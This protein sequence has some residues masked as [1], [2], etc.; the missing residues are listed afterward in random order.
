MKQIGYAQVRAV[1]TSLFFSA[2]V[3][4][5]VLWF[6][7]PRVTTST[8]AAM[9]KM[10]PLLLEQLSPRREHGRFLIE[11]H[12]HPITAMPNTAV[13]P[14]AR[15]ALLQAYQQA[16]AAAQASVLDTLQVLEAT[17]AVSE[18]R[19]LWIINAIAV[20]GSYTA[21]QQIAADPAVQLIRP[22]PIVHTLNP[23]RED[24]TISQF[25]APSSTA[26]SGDNW[27]PPR[28][29]APY[30]WHGLGI[31]GD[32]V[33]IAIMDS[34]VDWQHPVLL[35]N[36]RGNL[37]GG[38]YLH[39]G[40]WFDTDDP[41]QT[42]P[43]DLIGHGTHV[44]GIAVGQR[45]I[46]VAPGAQWI[47]VKIA[48]AQGNIYESDAHAGFQWLLAPDG[49]PNLAPDI[50]NGS[51]GSTQAN[52]TFAPDLALLRQAGIIPVFSTGNTG[53]GANTVG[54]PAGLEGVIAVGASAVDDTVASFSSRG[55]SPLTAEQKPW[56]VA[57]G[58]GIY[59]AL[60]GGEFGLKSGTSMAAP[61]VSGAVALLLSAQPDLSD[62]EVRQ[63]LADTVVPIQPPHPNNDAGYGRLDIY[64]SV[65]PYVSTGTFT[66]IVSEA[67]TPLADVQVMIVNS[68]GVTLTYRTGADG[69]FTAVLQPG[70]Y[71][72]QV[73]EFL[74][75]PVLYKDL[76]LPA[77][78]IYI[79]NIP[80]TRKPTGQ[81]SGKITNAQ[82][83]PLA[84][85]TVQVQQTGV[86]AVS[87]A[88]GSYEIHLPAGEYIL[89]TEKNGFRTALQ[90][91][92]VAAGAELT[93]NF[94]LVDAPTI[95]LVDSGAWYYGS[96][97]DYY[98]ATLQNGGYSYDLWT[99]HSIINDVP[100]EA[101]LAA[102][103]TVIWSAPLDSPGLI[104]ADAALTAYL[105]TGGNLFIAG[106]DVGFYDGDQFSNVRWWTEKLAAQFVGER[107]NV[108]SLAGIEETPFTGLTLPIN[109]PDSAGNQFLP[110]VSAPRTLS[111]T[112]S[113]FQYETGETGGLAAGRC[114]PYNILYLGAGL[115]GIG[116]A[117][118]RTQLLE[119]AITTLNAPPVQAGLIISPRETNEFALPG[120]QQVYTLTVQN[121]SETV[122]DTF[123]FSYD[124]T[125]FG[126]ELI[127]KTV[128]LGPCGRGE[129]V[130]QLSV[131]DDF[132]RDATGAA[133]VT[134][135]S[136]IAPDQQVE[137][138]FSIKTA[139]QILFVDDYRFYPR[140]ERYTAVLDELGLHYDHLHSQVPAEAALLQRGAF[141]Q[142]YELIIWYTGYD[143]FAPVT[144]AEAAALTSFLQN[145]GRL[146]LSSQDFLYY[147]QHSFLNRVF[148]DIFDY[149]D[150]LNIQA[151]HL[152]NSPFF[153]SR[154]P[155]NLMLDFGP[156]LNNADGLIPGDRSTPLVWG[157]QGLPAAVGSSGTG[158]RAIFW[159]IPWET[160]PEAERMALMR[161]SLAWL[162][163]LG[164]STFQP[165]QRTAIA[166]EKITYTLLLQNS[167]PVTR[168]ISMQNGLP[169][170]LTIL[171]GTIR[172]AASWDGANHRI[173]WN[174]FLPPG[175]QHA[176]SYQMEAG[177]GL[178][179]GMPITNSAM[180]TV[181]NGL[182]PYPLVRENVIWAEMPD[183]Q[184][185]LTAIANTPR[186][187]NRI[188]YTLTITNQG[189]AP[190]NPISVNVRLPDDLHFITD[191]VQATMP[192]TTII[193]G[194]LL[195]EGS[196]SKGEPLQ[197]TYGT[198]RTVPPTTK[199]LISTAVLNDGVTRPLLIQNL[200][201]L[202]TFEQILLQIH[203]AYE[204]EP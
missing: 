171:P 73:D 139:G 79:Q 86:T 108:T 21:V 19:P 173:F 39:A 156:Y 119:Q 203:N 112:T 103:E 1:F 89:R 125:D 135:V 124:S 118:G 92:G 165:H 188:T 199:R 195:W 31:D 59:S 67:G 52:D 23:D 46:G 29:G 126:G 45:D 9:G 51:W 81:I 34:G 201:E 10:D 95:L 91:A 164:D 146:F 53:P 90:S 38:Q 2:A 111:N 28:I 50:V 41:A 35:P 129:T 94:S 200:I 150:E 161:D 70:S 187:A 40:S 122:T 69:R 71:N 87:G 178:T 7:N 160:L 4:F 18:I 76:T 144:P 192:G 155:E 26:D 202:P 170:D 36:Y 107:T 44:A 60:P 172:G 123:S 179:P 140:G 190:S 157:D 142:A 148:L 78:Q 184:G 163:D 189:L 154:I 130:L 106:Q 197:I 181:A 177:T 15:S 158:W 128:E 127:T 114:R 99:I 63:A 13:D 120:D 84:A 147:H 8:A 3:L 115:E 104:G 133:T 47:A 141:L 100:T 54:T 138:R 17:G 132:P 110:D 98:I 11:F 102:Y 143:W 175:A 194:R 77:E 32:G 186:S 169:P 74:F 66:G 162:S 25:L 153:A 198:A 131:P 24:D 6:A 88:D 75:N 68:A 180:I 137:S 191:T 42:T 109:G 196:F 30:V 183:L 20:S 83:Q 48:D 121:L 16:A 159:G 55:P 93:L 61:H 56:L 12:P 152:Y 33:T 27:G 136:Q 85:V 113:I 145:G 168:H 58:T 204:A 116:D 134:A 97:V 101:D 166:G 64:R 193:P 174:G 167:G 176:I 49:D 96:M 82:N 37:G 105:E 22:D 14:A 57:P 185:T 72:L 80:L 182:L 117:D 151:V 62:N 149:Q 5:A 43:I 65:Q